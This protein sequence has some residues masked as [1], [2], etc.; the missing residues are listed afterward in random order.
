[1]LP[2][3]LPKECHADIYMLAKRRNSRPVN[4]Q[5]TKCFALRFLFPFLDERKYK[6]AEE[7]W[8]QAR[9]NFQASG[10]AY[11]NK[12]GHLVLSFEPAFRGL[13]TFSK[14]P[15]N[16][17]LQAKITRL[18]RRIDLSQ[19]RLR[20]YYLEHRNGKAY[21]IF[22]RIPN[23]EPFKTVMKDGKRKWFPEVEE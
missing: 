19:F 20:S 12:E 3:P 23:E 8:P 1:M 17:Y 11:I 15:G 4:L 22:P 6:E 9:I 10:K 16:S 18:L 7:A 14:T 5:M 21:I 13:M 2:A